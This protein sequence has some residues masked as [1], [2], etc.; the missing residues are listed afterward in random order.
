MK[1]A[2]PPTY[3]AETVA[4]WRHYEDIAMHFNSL[5]MQFRLQ[6]IGGAGAIG[7]LASYLIGEKVSPGQQDWLR[8]LVSS[9]LWLLI[10]SAAI[11]D[12]GY[13]N[14]LLRGAVNALLDFEKRH[15]EIQM[16]TEIERTVAGGRRAVN[17]S[18]AL[19]LGVLFVFASWAWYR[20]FHPVP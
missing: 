17:V 19:M 7:T 15:P 3:D 20:F 14:R 10:L 11:L 4:L 12:V 2:S 9:G 13:Y 18:Y 5:I 6:V 8:A 16:S 1:A